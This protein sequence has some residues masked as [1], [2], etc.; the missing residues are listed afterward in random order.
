[1][2]F[3]VSISLILTHI[4]IISLLLLDL[5]LACFH[6]SVSLNYSIRPFISGL[7]VFLIYAFM[8]ITFLLSIACAV[9]IGS[10]R[11]GLSL[12]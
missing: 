3:F 8:A 4:F 9:S 6:Y 11:F 5:G 7:S 1:V 10:D 12:F 2:C